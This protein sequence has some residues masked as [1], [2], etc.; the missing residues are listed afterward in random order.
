MVVLQRVE[1][2]KLKIGNKYLYNIECSISNNLTAPLLLGQNVLN[3]FG[4]V[5][6]DNERQILF[7]E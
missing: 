1:H 5:T 2:L 7:L 4:K 6:I 3:K